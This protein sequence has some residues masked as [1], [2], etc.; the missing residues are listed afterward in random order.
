MAQ[1]VIIIC[2][3]RAAKIIQVNRYS[4][5]GENSNLK[6]QTLAVVVIFYVVPTID[7]EE[8]RGNVLIEGIT[9]TKA[10]MR[11]RNCKAEQIGMT[12]MIVKSIM[13]FD[14]FQAGVCNK[15]S[16]IKAQSA[17]IVGYI[18]LL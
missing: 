3:F 7:Q 5:M 6:T 4:R 8:Q 17:K 18:S 14:D 15:F 16:E 12:V 9:G 2:L 10:G 11:E 1:V 13:S